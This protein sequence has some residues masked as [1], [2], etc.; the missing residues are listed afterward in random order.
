MHD[1]AERERE[2]GDDVDS[3]ND[4]QHR[5]LGKRRQRVGEQSELSG[6]SP[7]AL[8]IDIASESAERNA[9]SSLVLQGL[10]SLNQR[11]RVEH[12]NEQPPAI[13]GFEKSVDERVFAFSCF[14]RREEPLSDL[15]NDLHAVDREMG[16]A[17]I[18]WTK[19]GRDPASVRR[20]LAP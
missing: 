12:G 14:G 1:L 20:R 15:K 18:G 6:S 11:G 10:N 17:G 3:R 5:Q 7:S 9:R 4:F 2:I 13:V 16:F 8:Q 19:N